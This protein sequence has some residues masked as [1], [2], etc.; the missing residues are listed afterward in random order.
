MIYELRTYFAA[1]GKLEA[2]H[3]RFRDVTLGVFAKYDMQVVGFWTPENPTD[4]TGDLIYILAFES[5]EAMQAAWAAFRDDPDWVH[6][7]EA[8]EVNGK[9][10]TRVDSVLMVPT[11]YSPLQ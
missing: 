4:E 3:A 7:R 10:V 6:G 5:K 2:L 11:D 1:E 9:L 8:S